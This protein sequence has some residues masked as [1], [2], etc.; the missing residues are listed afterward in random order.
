MAGRITKLPEIQQD[1]VTQIMRTVIDSR[2]DV[3]VRELMERISEEDDPVQDRMWSLVAQFGLIDARRLMSVIEA[4]I[5]TIEQ[6]QRALGEGAR[7]V[8]DIH[9]LVRK[10]A[11]LLDPRWHLLGDEIN[12]GAIPGVNFEPETDAETGHELDYLFALAPT[13]PAIVD[14]VVVVEIKRGTHRN[15]AIRR[16]DL[17]EVQKFQAYVAAIQQHYSAADTVPP[18]VRGLMVAQ[19]YTPQADLVRRQLE[20]LTS[21]RFEFKSWDRVLDETRRMHMGWLRVSQTRSEQN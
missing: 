7:E 4:R 13:A 16:A 14:E 18:T 2:S 11:W 3:Q 20:Q 21:P 5:A 1:D 12:L 17:P 15:G 19:G 9:N 10:D 8:P 6:L